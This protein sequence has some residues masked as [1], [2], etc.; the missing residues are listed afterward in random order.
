[1]ISGPESLNL[2]QFPSKSLKVRTVL[3]TNL[4][5]MRSNWFSLENISRSVNGLLIVKEV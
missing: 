4:A 5:D 1:M 3:S 2:L